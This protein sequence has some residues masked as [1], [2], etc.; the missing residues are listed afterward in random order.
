[1][2]RIIST[3]TLLTLLGLSACEDS[4]VNSTDNS[5]NIE[6]SNLELSSSVESSSSSSKNLSSSSINVSSSAKSSALSSAVSSASL[7]S[8]ST[9][10]ASSSSVANSVASSNVASSSSAASNVASSSSLEKSSSSRGFQGEVLVDDRDGE[11]YKT[12]YI[13]NQRWM[14]ENL[15]FKADKKDTLSSS[16]VKRLGRYYDWATAVDTT[17]AVAKTEMFPFSRAQRKGICPSGWHLPSYEELRV[18][19]L[20]VSALS[21]KPFTILVSESDGWKTGDNTTGFTALP[22]GY[23]DVD[24]AQYQ[25]D[26]DAYFWSSSPAISDNAARLS[27]AIVLRFANNGFISIQDG[28]R[29]SKRVVR[30]IED[31]EVSEALDYLAHKEYSGSYGELKDSRDGKSYKTVVLGKHEWMAENLNFESDGSVCAV[32]LDSCAKYGRLYPVS[33]F[34]SVCPTGWHVPTNADVESLSPFK[35]YEYV[36][37]HELKSTSGWETGEGLWGAYDGNG[38]NA[39]GLNLLPQGFYS[40]ARSYELVYTGSGFFVDDDKNNVLMVMTQKK[41]VVYKKYLDGNYAPVRCVK[42]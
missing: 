31:S 23:Y 14:A 28:V 26:T 21:E 8:S 12:V 17:E 13:G 30:C 5:T 40:D 3:C 35:G 25:Q 39:I 1:M 27:H 41:E 34:K 9:K 7:S 37:G 38:S 16:T 11:K 18:F 19:N 4:G 29:L 20:E 24:G 10:A 32:A 33:G 22:T 6:S 15:R 42:N 2:K 36:M